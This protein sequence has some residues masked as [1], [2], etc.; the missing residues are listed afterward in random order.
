MKRTKTITVYVYKPPKEVDRLIDS[1]IKY[2]KALLKVEKDT[3]D[4]RPVITGENDFI[5]QRR[6]DNWQTTHQRMETA[7][8]SAAEDL[9]DK[10]EKGKRLS[11]AR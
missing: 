10:H 6:F 7:L 9:Y 5:G 2:H 8:F 1:A 3:K 4:N 11:D